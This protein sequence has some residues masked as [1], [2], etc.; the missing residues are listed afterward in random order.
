MKENVSGCFFLNTEYILKTVS[1][2]IVLP[3]MSMLPYCLFYKLLLTVRQ[4]HL[5]LCSSIVVILY[6]EFSTVELSETGR[7]F[8][9]LLVC[10]LYR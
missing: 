4:V 2:F 7:R 9:T 3:Y 10:V 8:I 5:L 6:P 1:V